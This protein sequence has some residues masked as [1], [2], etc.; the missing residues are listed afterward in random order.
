MAEDSFDDLDSLLEIDSFNVDSIPVLIIGREHLYLEISKS[1]P[2]SFGYRFTHADSVNKGLDFLIQHTYALLI[3]DAHIQGFDVIKISINIKKT[4]PLTRQL[5]LTED[6]NIDF[7]SNIF[8]N[9]SVDAILTWPVDQNELI[10][11]FGE[12]EAKYSINKMVTEF[13]KEPPRLSKAGIL[14]LDPSIIGDKDTPVNFV[15]I[16]IV[17]NTVPVYIKWF[18][19][20]LA[21]DDILV[22]GY[23]SSITA[24]GDE[25]FHADESLK[26]I[27][28]GGV[29]VIFRFHEEFQFC[30][31]VKNLNQSN[32]SS[33]EDRI[34]VLLEEILSN[35]SSQLA[36]DTLTIEE[37]DK[38]ENI[39]DAFDRD[40][41]LL[42]EN[43]QKSKKET[44]ETEEIP[45]NILIFSSDLAIPEL[46]GPELES[47][48]KESQ[49]FQVYISSIEDE[50]IKFINSNRIG[51]L[52]LDY[53]IR[54]SRTPLD[55]ADFSK[56]MDPAIQIF[57][58]SNENKINDHIIK[59]LNSDVIDKIFSIKT[60]AQEIAIHTSEGLNKAA[61]FRSQSKSKGEDDSLDNL[62]VAKMKLRKNLDDYQ[63][64]VKP[65]LAGIIISENMN[66]IYDKFW[67]SE[68][69]VEI[70]KN[71]IT[72][73][74]TSLKDIGGE[75][76]TSSEQIDGLELGG[77]DVF[78]RER[79]NYVFI[80]FVNKIK[81]NTSVIVSK[82][83]EEIT[84]A[85][86]SVL[87][88]A[89][90]IPYEH[91]RPIFDR[92]SEETHKKFTSL[93]NAKN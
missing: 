63:E 70:D 25:L 67:E 61:I 58:I 15:G 80:Y 29:S 28:F 57:M 16:I 76:F 50:S 40:D 26:E 53:Q 59:G 56:E 27:N 39:L 66:L 49:N 19:E 88:E 32:V 41:Q 8:N 93:L 85:Y 38:L 23:L 86:Y 5:L 45:E 35:Y 89:E 21:Q 78:V 87:I 3:L 13:V 77:I 64:E 18:E 74:I 83:V 14:L 72:G 65:E 34:E 84:D 62:A 30:F 79:Q 91:L 12:Q 54:A 10:S 48:N 24:I 71:M 46:Y 82:E 44:K 69:T 60:S 20:T 17:H 75:M 92:F 73:M 47:I 37:E 36:N 7:L 1:I 68:N 4:Q 52:I 9:G 43:Y 51:V 33:A 90:G 2:E 42:F 55:F 31:L 81:E 22:A 6:T 11:N